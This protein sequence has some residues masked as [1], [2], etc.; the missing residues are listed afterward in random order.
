MFLGCS[1]LA[2]PLQKARV[3]IFEKIEL[4]H[5]RKFLV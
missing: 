5:R 1:G 2:R 3:A 4:E